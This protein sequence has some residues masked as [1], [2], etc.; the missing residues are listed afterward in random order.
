MHGGLYGWFG[1][2]QIV[3]PYKTPCLECNPLIPQKRLQKPCTPLGK[4]RKEERNEISKE[5]EEKIPSILTTTSIIAGIQSQIALKLILGLS[6]PEENYIF[7]DGLSESFTKLKLNKNENC[8][9]CSDKY[10]IK[11]VDLAVSKDDTIRDIKDRIIMTWG[12]PEPFNFVYKGKIMNDEIK[13]SELNIKNKD[14]F[15]VWNKDILQPMKFYAILSDEITPT[16]L[17]FRPPS[18]IIEL[19]VKYGKVTQT[20][21]NIIN[22]LRKLNQAVKFYKTKR[23]PTGEYLIR[24][25]I[26]SGK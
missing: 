13:L 3:I 12:L 18:K 26:I 10:K 4:I 2:V 15:Y 8:I 14:T 22:E 9:V 21:Q 7:Y 17:T 5:V 20:K 1:N 16:K 24:Y 19:K 25:K 11:G 6:L 23:L